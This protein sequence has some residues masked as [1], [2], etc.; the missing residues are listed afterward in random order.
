MKARKPQ[1]QNDILKKNQYK[2]GQTMLG[3]LNIQIFIMIVLG[4][5]A[6]IFFPEYTHFLVPVGDAF[7]RLL[8]MLIIPLILSSIIIGM[9]SLNDMGQLGRM[10][11]RTGAYF[12]GT[13]VIASALGIFL[14]FLA[15]PGIDAD[16]PLVAS[17]VVGNTATPSFGI[18][19]TEIIPENVVAAMAQGQML[20]TIFFALILG[21]ALM[22]IGPKG[23]KMVEI[24]DSFNDAILKMVNW[25]MQLAPIG[26]FALIASMVGRTGLEVLG[27]LGK[28]M[29]VVVAGLLIHGLVVLPILLLLFGKTH[30]IKFLKDLSPALGM[31][32]STS[33]SMA[34][35]PLT[36]Q[37]LKN[38]EKISNKIISFVCPLGATINMDGTALFQSVTAVFIAQLYGVDLSAMEL[39]IVITTATLASIG[40][41]AIP[42]AGLITLAI[43]LNAI[44]LPLEALGM[45]LA[46]DRLLDMGRTTVNVLTDAVGA[47]IISN[48]EE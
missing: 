35:L 26:V 15:A 23:Q 29:L 47:N 3:K 37:C 34:T 21:A 43:I 33:S 5:L 18:L 46:V 44:G 10:G 42:S 17:P 40:A 31:A 9:V 4:I 11:V 39:L 14:T 6:G 22:A 41:A 27:P 20:P 48:Y 30:P 2:K 38:R 8:K 16:I 1:S 32:F 19:F 12:I 13:T 45:I 36:M 7:L 25:I 24:I 28:F